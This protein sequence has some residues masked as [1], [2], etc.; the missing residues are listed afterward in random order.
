MKNLINYLYFIAS[1]NGIEVVVTDRLESHDTDIAIPAARKV[2]INEN[3]ST[4]IDVSFRLAHELSHILF[5]NSESDEVYSFSIGS[6][7]TS[8][9]NANK[10]ALSMITKFVYLDTPLEYRNYINF[11]NAFG[12]PSYF[13]D[14]VKEAIEAV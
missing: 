9:I 10:N 2:I 11:M 6:Q 5:G 13:E 1:E 8:E 3:S 12:L 7:R 14:M 4:N